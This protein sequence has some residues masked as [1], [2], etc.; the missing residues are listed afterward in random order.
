MLRCKNQFLLALAL[1]ASMLLAACTLFAATQ[2]QAQPVEARGI[3]YDATPR[4]Y[5]QQ[6]RFMGA[7]LL[8]ED[9][10]LGLEDRVSAHWP[11]SVPS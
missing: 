2:A 7:V 9:G 6:G 10:K 8:A 11:A 4:R 3:D 1:A 5:L